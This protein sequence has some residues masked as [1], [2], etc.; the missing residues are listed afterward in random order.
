M[1]RILAGSKVIVTGASSGI[2]AA[3][4]YELVK[5]GADVLI[6]ARRG[7]RLNEIIAKVQNEYSDYS[8]TNGM[9]KIVPVVGD[10]TEGVVRERIIGVARE[11]LGGLDILINNAGVGATSLIEA[12]NRDTLRRIL[13]V[14]F[15]ALF[16][17]TQLAIPLLKESA[18]LDINKKLK[19][20][21][22]VVNLSSIVGLRGVPHY[23][24]Y[25]AAKFAVNGLS[26]TM[27]AEFKKHGIDVLVVCPGTTSSEFFD[28]LYQS[29]SAPSMPIHTAVTPEYVASRI[30]N[31]MKRGK[32]KIIPYFQA[33]ILYYLNRFFPRFTD[34]IMTKYV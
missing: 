15:F 12:T 13:E 26:E 34:W 10:I 7:E 25:G 24:V 5:E 23:G 33:V 11:E 6:T 19:I 30:V 18:L 29:S 3:V 20:H 28:V 22:M 21:P 14:N 4:V 32:H 2:G 31:A 1:K 17:M 16:E 8:L 9:R 27:R